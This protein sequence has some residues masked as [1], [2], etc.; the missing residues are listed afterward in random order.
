MTKSRIALPVAQ[1]D[2]G[3]PVEGVGGPCCGKHLDALRRDGKARRGG[4]SPGGRPLDHVPQVD[5][6]LLAAT[7]QITWMRAE[8]STTSRK[9]SF[10]M[11]RRAIALPAIRRV[12]QASA[13]ASSGSASAQTVAIASLSGKR[14]RR[15]V[16]HRRRIGHAFGVRPRRTRGTIRRP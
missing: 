15:L 10:P 3:E 4:T 7:S 13:P 14:W 12:V 2:V 6:E 11:P 9:T 5:V 16:G 8:R 1:L